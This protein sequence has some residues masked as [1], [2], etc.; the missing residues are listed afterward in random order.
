MNY[1]SAVLWYDSRLR[2]W[3]EYWMRFDCFK[4]EQVW[5]VVYRVMMGFVRFCKT[6]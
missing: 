4:S 2:D 6:I 5:W 3:V 1:V